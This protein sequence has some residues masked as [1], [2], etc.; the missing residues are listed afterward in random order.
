M[1]QYT[2]GLAMLGGG[3]GSLRPRLVV[4]VSAQHRGGDVSQGP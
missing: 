2:A 3:W 1:L 4:V